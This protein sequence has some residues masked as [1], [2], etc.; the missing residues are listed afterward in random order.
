MS[1]ATGTQL[2]SKAFHILHLFDSQNREMSLAEIAKKT[3][4]HPATVHRI[5]Q[6]LVY[7]GFMS[8]DP[9]SSRYSLGMG[10]VK[11][12]ELAKQSNSLFEISKPYAEELAK[13]FGE[14]ITIEFLN[15]NLEMDTL[16]FIPSSYR[17]GETP[18]IDISV[19]A[20]CTATGK[21]MLAS[22]PDE[23]IEQYLQKE[24]VALTPKTITNTE[25]L[26]SE[27][28]LVREQKYAVNWEEL[29]VGLMAVAAPLLD[30]NQHVIAGLSIGGPVSRVSE[31]KLQHMKTEVMQAARIV[32]AALR[33]R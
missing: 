9:K 11:M 24:L 15:S 4:Y 18:K 32:S 6:A 2:L 23:Q 3:E 29:E 13:K 26:R 31:D 12:G 1:K 27:L 25:K 30:F 28:A 17:L 7:E 20:H 19:P 22:L 33:G 8:Q 16:L 5:L 21:I 14:T 10:L